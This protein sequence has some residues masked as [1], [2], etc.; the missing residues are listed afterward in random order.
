MSVQDRVYFPGLNGIR[1]IAAY[2]VIIHHVEQ[3]K[4][5]AKLPNVWGTNV[6]IDSLGHRGVA[7]FFTLSGFLITYLLMAEIKKTQTVN[8]YKF[9]VR[10][11]LR[12]WPLY[13]FITLFTF[14][15]LPHVVTLPGISGDL[16]TGFYVKLF[17]YLILIPNIARQMYPSVLGSNQAWS[18]GIEEQFY[19]FWPWL[20]KWFKNHLFTFLVAFI[21]LKTLAQLLFMGVIA[22]YPDEAWIRYVRFA[23]TAWRFLQI[24]QMAVG[25]IGAY[26]LFYGY[27]KVLNVIYH[28]V[29]MWST[30]AAVIGS[31][32][33]HTTVVGFSIAE[34]VL[35]SVVILNVSTNPACPVKLNT[36]W[37]QKMGDISYGIYMYHTICL[38]VVIRVLMNL[39]LPATSWVGF[40]IIMYTVPGFMTLAVAWLSYRYFETPFIKLKEKFMVVKSST[41]KKETLQEE[42]A[43]Q[44]ADLMEM[45]R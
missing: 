31:L 27:R 34:A 7:L 38:A 29:V 20:I 23:N 8:V 33:V 9:Y 40:N 5:W 10:R 11:S 36:G 32:L 30:F 26:V 16:N 41:F 44:K 6:V 2:A 13:Y 37:L 3:T 1:F 19:A 21:V 39:N 15:V 22:L 12:I 43:Q 24:E 18:V 42:V 25:A 35:Y 28:P 4:Y 45:K 14:F 17:L